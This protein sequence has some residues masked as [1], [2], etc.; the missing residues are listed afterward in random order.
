[1]TL[2]K[3]FHVTLETVTPLFLGGADARPKDGVEGMPEVRP[4][5]I[6]GA[7]RYWF[8]ALIGG[9]YG[10]GKKDKVQELEGH[11]F[12]SATDKNSSHSSRVAIR[13]KNQNLKELQKYE[14]IRGEN[15][16][17]LFPPAGRDYLYWSMDKSGSKDKNNLLLAR[18]FIPPE[19]SFDLSLTFK[20]IPDL[21]MIKEY[22]AYSFWLAMQL[23]G[24]GA[25]SRRT[26]GS[27]FISNAELEYLPE[28]LRIGTKKD[29]ANQLG[30]II[31]GM[32][33]NLRTNLPEP[34]INIPSKF[35]TLHPDVCKIW[36]LG[37]AETSDM[38]VKIIGEKMQAYRNNAPAG[39]NKDTWLLERSIFG[40]PVKGLKGIERRSSPLWLKVS[41]VDD[42]YVGLATLFKSQLLP[43]G[44]KIGYPDSQG[45]RRFKAPNAD[46]GIIEDWI[47]KNFKDVAEVTYE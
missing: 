30:K 31:S 32:R 46:Y 14:K 43:N 15:G 39:Q 41:K 27:I 12:G 21:E 9:I 11:I 40:M 2:L 19:S 36:V 6:R 1:M 7:L 44:E 10:D 20:G 26:A 23:G 38:L 4:P 45:M 29:L 22:T 13:I 5:S 24:I 28:M 47:Q 34:H 3:E 18:Y 35:D 8:R 37:V 42:Y 33:E 16:R 25:R 17:A